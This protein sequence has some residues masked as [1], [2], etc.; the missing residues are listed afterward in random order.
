MIWELD[1]TKPSAVDITAARMPTPRS[2]ANHAGNSSMKSS[3]KALLLV[4]SGS[5]STSPRIARARRPPKPSI[6]KVRPK[7]KARLMN[8][9]RSLGFSS[10]Q[11]LLPMWGSMPNGTWARSTASTD[12]QEW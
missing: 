11:S 5:V 2:A 12:H 1:T 7:V 3:A 4:A 8:R 9:R 6:P 10:A